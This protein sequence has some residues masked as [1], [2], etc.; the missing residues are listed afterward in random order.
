MGIFNS[1]VVTGDLDIQGSIYGNGLSLPTGPTGSTGARGPCGP[2][3]DTGITGAR[4]PCGPSGN[5][6]P[7][8]GAKGP[9]GP[10]GAPNPTTGA[11]GP[12]GP[13]GYTG[14]TGA[15]GPCG[16]SGYKG[17]IG[18]KPNSRAVIKYYTGSSTIGVV[19]GDPTGFYALCNNSSST[20]TIRE[21]PICKTLTSVMATSF[22]IAANQMHLAYKT[23]NDSGNMVFFLEY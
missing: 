3:G 7:T 20:I 21:V 5:S 6:N 22:T 2:Q 16:P 17:A 18:V 14:V 11:K 1:L 12:C 10:S 13:Q 15:K 23:V 19:A 4:G 8:T 9:C